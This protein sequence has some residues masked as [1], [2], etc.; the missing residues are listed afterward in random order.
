MSGSALLPLELGAVTV[1]PSWQR[2]D[3]GKAWVL[4]E[5][6]LG[7][8][9]IAWASEVLLQPD[10][11][12]AGEPFRF[13]D[14]QAR[15]LL[16]WYALDEGGKFT[17][18]RGVLRRLKGWGKD[19]FSAAVCLVELLGPCR[20]D[21]WD[22]GGEPVAVP[23]PAP[24]IQ[25]CAVN[26]EQTK[27]TMSLFAGLLGGK[28]RAKS[29]GVDLGKQLIHLTGD[30]SGRLESVSSSP[31]SLEGARPSFVVKNE[32]QHWLADQNQGIAMEQAIN[33]NL[34][35]SRDGSGRSLA[36]TNAHEPGEGS[37]AEQDWEAYVK[38]ASGKSRASGF[39]YDSLEAPVGTQIDD[40]ES[41]RE[42]LL[43]ARGDSHW[44]D[45]D[46]LAE[47]VMDPAQPRQ[48]SAR[49]YLNQLVAADDSWLSPTEWQKCEDKSLVLGFDEPITL[50]FDGSVS[51][52]HTAL[53]ACRVEDSALFVLGHWAPADQADG[54]ID[55]EAVRDRVEEVLRTRDVVAFYADP[56][57]FE[58]EVDGWNRE[59]SDELLVKAVTGQGKT[60]H[61]I[62]WDMRARGPE[63]TKAVERFTA[64]VLSQS[65]RHDGNAELALHVANAKR[66]PNRYGFSL[67]KESRES[68]RKIDLAVAAV[69]AHLAKQDLEA[70]G[71]LGRRSTASSPV[72]AF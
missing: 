1:G 41:L 65:V 27:N 48:L 39:L 58:S 49:F 69:L 29:F 30:R 37:V 28:N 22:E 5:R 26:F 23:H 56:A 11:P 55:R 60:N 70:T 54:R 15:F 45:V 67:R 42:G 18:R 63:F 12:N 50:A 3:D 16:W 51:G 2:T 59:F 36:I 61:A 43:A 25:V 52:D 9:A 33:R 10:G 38:I 8:D 13:T 68:P 66:R 72:F 20:F 62:R 19:P 35:K 4:P 31:R 71:G 34:A 53:V 47:E 6:T 44:V 57:F 17:F 40:P 7:W 24:W 32:T 21:G 64:L 14:E 46:R